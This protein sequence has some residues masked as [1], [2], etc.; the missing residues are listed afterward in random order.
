MSLLAVPGIALLSA[1]VAQEVPTLRLTSAPAR[2]DDGFSWISSVRELADGRVLASVS[3][4]PSFVVLDF[5]SGSIDEVSREGSGPGEYRGEVGHLRALGGDSTLA[6]AGEGR[7]LVLDGT[8]PVH[9]ISA[10]QRGMAG[11]S[12]TLA[13]AD[14]SG[15]LLEV[16]ATRYGTQPGARIYQYTQNA[17]SLA[18]IIHRRPRL[19]SKDPIAGRPDTLAVIRGP[20]REV[21]QLVRGSY[22]GGGIHY[23]LYTILDGPEQAVMY[24]DG[25]VAIA[26]A[27]PYRV[28]WYTSDR[29]RVAGPPLPFERVRVDE[30]QKLAA[31][32]RDWSRSPTMFKPDEYPPW[33]E[34]LPPFQEHALV[35]MA[36]GRL[37]IMRTPDANVDFIL[38]DLVD[39]SGRLTARLQLRI[40]QRLK[41]VTGK[42]AYV[43]R[44]DR[45]DLVWLER[46]AWPPG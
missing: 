17:E 14:A 22:G 38:Y 20:F 29:N 32:A 24:P 26:Y 27:I 13:G 3:P 25:W 43:E 16:E 39:R 9:M 45:D 4:K 1:V 2:L 12:A 23:T 31:I 42:Y 30:K 19:P 6:P 18:V 36:D 10:W 15:H 41:A 8:T 35:A 11:M 40:H 34:F 28:E 5:T 37:A 21:R 7:W 33:P 46:F 44:R